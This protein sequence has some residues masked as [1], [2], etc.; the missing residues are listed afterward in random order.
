M[1]LAG[2][3]IGVAAFPQTLFEALLIVVESDSH[4]MHI[5]KT[6][7]PFKVCIKPWRG[8]SS[9]ALDLLPIETNFSFHGM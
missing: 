3:R 6:F 4:D 7:A 2:Q 9:A 5:G 8:H 1:S